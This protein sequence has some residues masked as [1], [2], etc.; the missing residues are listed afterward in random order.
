LVSWYWR[1]RKAGVIS[2]ACCVC[3]WSL[4]CFAMEQSAALCLI[5]VTGS[6]LLS[7]LA[8]EGPGFQCWDAFHNLISMSLPSVS[9]PEPRVGLFWLLHVWLRFW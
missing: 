7:T 2:A 1:P 4:H 5:L 8:S 3:L 9:V 6:C